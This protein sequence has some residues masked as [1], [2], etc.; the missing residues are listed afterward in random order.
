M[1]K[2]VFVSSSEENREFTDKLIEHLRRSGI[3]AN[4]VLDIADSKDRMEAVPRYIKDAD[5]FVLL[6]GRESG[7]AQRRE[8]QLALEETWEH[9]DKQFIPVLLDDDAKLPAFLSGDEQVIVAASPEGAV[10]ED[11][12]QHLRSASTPAVSDKP[13]ADWKKRLDYIGKVAAG[14]KKNLA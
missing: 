1:S 10:F 4:S 3:T 7:E 11:V 9:L 8:W 5:A 12:L 14:L 2:R 6:V 13:S